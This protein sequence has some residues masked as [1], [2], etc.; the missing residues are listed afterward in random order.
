M[1]KFDRVSIQY[2]GFILMQKKK[3]FLLKLQSDIV[4]RI[5]IICYSIVLTI[6][7]SAFSFVKN[8][9]FSY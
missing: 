9:L 5:I 2:Y 1:I 8:T 6:I 3:K 7:D 4:I